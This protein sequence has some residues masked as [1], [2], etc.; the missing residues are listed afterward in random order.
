MP[1]KNNSRVRVDEISK[2]NSSKYDMYRL[3][4]RQETVKPVSTQNNL[5]F[6]MPSIFSE[7]IEKKI[8][9]QNVDKSFIDKYK[10][11]QSTD[12]KVCY[13]AD[14]ISKV[15]GKPVDCKLVVKE[16]LEQRKWDGGEQS[17]K[18]NPDTGDVLTAD[19]CPIYR[20]TMLT[21]D[22]D[23]KDEY[24]AHDR[25]QTITAKDVVKVASNNKLPY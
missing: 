12:D 14:S 24:I 15:E 18:I 11:F 5:A 6:F 22:M 8:T 2:I 25:I 1:I 23:E 21:F 4:L 16:T 20:N 10:L 7:N 13:L 9:W 17:P 3:T 19:G